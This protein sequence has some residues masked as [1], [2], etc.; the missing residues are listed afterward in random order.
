M[1]GKYNIS[2][3]GMDAYLWDC[4]KYMWRKV[5]MDETEN[6]IYPLQWWIDTGRASSRGLNLLIAKK[7]YVI[8]RF[9]ISCSGYTVDETVRLVKRYI[10][11]E[12]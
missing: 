10:G 11:L 3:T 1:A 6:L 5:G 12:A 4:R 2:Y 8:G 9:L 7:P